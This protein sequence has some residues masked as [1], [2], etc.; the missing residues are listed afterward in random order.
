MRRG[1]HRLM[2]SVAGIRLLLGQTMIVELFNSAAKII[3]ESILE[4]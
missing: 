1:I 2:L 3:Y 4:L